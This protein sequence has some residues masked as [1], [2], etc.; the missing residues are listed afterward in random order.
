[1]M[2]YNAFLQKILD[3]TKKSSPDGENYLK[4]ILALE[5]SQKVGD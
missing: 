2:G 3:T 5:S 1:M 4:N